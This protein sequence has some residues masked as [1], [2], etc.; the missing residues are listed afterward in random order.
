ML[1]CCDYIT[2]RQLSRNEIKQYHFKVSYYRLYI[3][4]EKIEKY[5]AKEGQNEKF[6][7]QVERQLRE[8]DYKLK[9]VEQQLEILVN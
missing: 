8:I 3:F 4:R 9:L 2:K 6:K 5:L 1:G 7:E